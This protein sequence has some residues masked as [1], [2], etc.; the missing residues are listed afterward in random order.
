MTRSAARSMASSQRRPDICDTGR[1]RSQIAW[2]TSGRPHD[3]RC[4][5]TASTTSSTV[6]AS[7][8]TRLAGGVV[9][10]RRRAARRSSRPRRLRSATVSPDRPHRARTCGPG[11]RRASRVSAARSHRDGVR[12]S[13][14][15]NSSSLAARR[16]VDLGG[17]A[18]RTPSSSSSGTP[19]IS[20]W[21][22]TIG[23]H[24]TPK[25]WVSSARSTDWYRP[26]SIRWCRFR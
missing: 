11:V 4:A 3:D 13:R 1:C 25:R 22:L 5:D 2:I 6:S 9:R 24:S 12:P 14:W 7:A 19:A 16:R 23:R 10:C 18:S 8:G 15:R 20:A 26:P 21:P 17:C